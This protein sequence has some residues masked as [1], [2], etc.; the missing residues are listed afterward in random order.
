[1]QAQEEE[2]LLA[3]N[4]HDEGRELLLS[5]D[6]ESAESPGPKQSRDAPPDFLLDSENT[7]QRDRQFTFS[8]RE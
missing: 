4:R 8:N 2:S 5:G 3:S 6:F 1:M 7:S